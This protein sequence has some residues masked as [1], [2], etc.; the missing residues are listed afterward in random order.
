MVNAQSAETVPGHLVGIDPA[1][2]DWRVKDAAYWRAVLTPQQFAVCRESA[3]ERPFSGEYCESHAPGRYRCV[4]C[5]RDLFEAGMK[6]DSGTGWP[7]FTAP[8]DEAGVKEVPDRSHGMVRIEVRCSR[9]DAH[10]GHVFDD[11]PPPTGRR[12]CINSVCLFR[13]ALGDGE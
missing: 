6:F 8:F 4:C 7:S 2:V 10:L 13:V 1:T 5:G 12:Y 11:G 9:C 3:T